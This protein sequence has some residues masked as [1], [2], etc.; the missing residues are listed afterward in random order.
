MRKVFA[1]MKTKHFIFLG[2]S[3]IIASWI[4]TILLGVDSIVPYHDQLDGEII[5]YIY[6]AKYLFANT[7][8]IPEFLNGA[9]KTAL[10][11]P[12]PFAVG[13]F[14]FLSPFAAY[15]ALQFIGQLTA[16][17]GMFFL[18][19]H[20]NDRNGIAFVVAIL[21]TFLP[22]LPVY[23]LAHYGAPLLLVCFWNLYHNRKHFLSYTYIIL[24]AGMSSFV[25]IGFAWIALA[26]GVSLYFII[27]KKYRGHIHFFIASLC[28]LFTYLLL[29]LSLITQVLGISEGF[30]SHK[31]DY[32]LN[33]VPFLSNFVA[34]VF[35]DSAHVPDLHYIIL[36]IAVGTLIISV[37]CNKKWNGQELRLRKWL[38]LDL[39]FLCMIYAV[40]ACWD[41]SPV[42]SV[43][44]SLGALGSLQLSRFNWITPVF[45]YIALAISLSLLWSQKANLRFFRYAFSV[46]L[47]SVLSFMTVKASLVKP[48]VQELILTDYERLSWSD[49]YALD[50]MEEVESYICETDGLAINEYKV[51]SLGI[52]PCAALY[53][54]FYCVDGYSNNYPQEYKLAFRPVIG[55]ELEKSDWLKSYY[56]DWGNR[57]YLHAYESQGYYNIEK[58][59]FYY[60][61]LDLDTDTLKALGCDYILSAAYIVYPENMNLTL[62]CE[63]PISTE[64]SYYNIYI[65]KINQ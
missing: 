42:V 21:Y 37:F 57:C 53:H 10:T 17:L 31:I 26:A 35:S 48:C 23:G 29:N 25:L 51:A 50:V 61:D 3:V 8:Y 2:L 65:Y 4:P 60:V 15:L 30:V 6:Q 32:T 40:C 63:N 24:Y 27:R 7:D 19:R 56:D 41:I 46:L 36:F 13:L 55:A 62:L 33:S 59:T 12:A 16:F 34:Y 11:P 28:L 58:G 20:L 38:L 47:I 52:D 1:K 54:G 64:N 5:A 45:W 49:Y 18:I 39:L 43:R 9:P 44:T 14:L 22:F